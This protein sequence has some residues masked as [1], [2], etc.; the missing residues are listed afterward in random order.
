[1]C[2]PCAQHC[3][4]YF[5]CIISFSQ[6]PYEISSVITPILQMKKLW[7]RRIKQLAPVHKAIKWNSQHLLLSS[8]AAES[9]LNYQVIVPPS[10]WH[11]FTNT[12]AFDFCRMD[13][14]IP[15]YASSKA[16][17]SCDQFWTAQNFIHFIWHL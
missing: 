4:K 6:P 12:K 9:T 8:L 11:T 10:Q 5:P 16:L 13:F 2:L 17:D 15:M 1:M 3:S 7:I 14:E